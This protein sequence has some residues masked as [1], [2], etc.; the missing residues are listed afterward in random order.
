MIRFHDMRVHT[1]LISLTLVL[2]LLPLLVVSYLY[3]HRFNAALRNAAEV[4]LDHLVRNIHAMCKGQE[5]LVQ[6]K[7]VSDLRV[8]REFLFR[9]GGKIE[10]LQGERTVFDAVHPVTREVVPVDLPL[11]K[12]GDLRLTFDRD[13]VDKIQS[14]MGGICTIL[15]RVEGD[16]LLRIA[17]NVRDREGRRA[18]GTFIPPESPVAQSILSGQ[19]YRGR[20]FVIDAW[21]ITAYDPLRD[22]DGRVIGALNVG[23]R[24]RSSRSLESE[25]Q[26]IRVGET[27]YAYIMD[28]SGVLKVHPA[29]PGENIIDSR[30]SSGFEY[31]RAMIDEAVRLP[32][33]QVGTIRYPWMNPELG[34]KFPRQKITKYLYFRPWDWIIAAGTYEEEIY[35]ALYETERFI[36]IVILVT[37]PMVFLLTI[38]VSK[39]LTGRIQALTQATTRMVDGDL[40]QR[41]EIRGG[42]ELGILGYSFN[43][44]AAQIEDYTQNLQR[45]VEERTRELT[46]SRE[47][48]RNLSRFLNSILESATHYAIIALDFNGEITEFNR[49][50]EKLFGWKKEEVVGRENI[51]ITILAEDR[52]RGIQ[53]EIVRRTRVEGLCELEMDRLSKDGRRFPA[54]TVVTAMMDPSGKVT[55]FV[56]IVRDL[57]LRRSLERQ[58]RETKEFLE[59]IMASSVDGIVTTDLR[60]YITYLNRGME[61]ML[62]YGRE[63]LLGIHI[64][65]LYVRGIQEARDIMAILRTKETTENYGMEVKSKEGR[66][67]SI[68]NSASL[69]RDGEGN[70]IG[71]VGVFKDV[72]EQKR[73][74]AKLRETQAHLVEASKLRALGELVSGVAH[75][76]NNPLMASQTILHVILQNLH[77]ECPN[78]DRLEIVRRCN[79]RIEK[80]VD[81]LREFSRQARPELRPIDINQPVENA[82]LITGQQLL[83]HSIHLNRELTPGLPR[84]RGDGNQIEQV[85]LNLIS[86]ARDALDE[87]E[88]AKELTIR[89][90]TESRDSLPWVVASVR[91]T[92][93]GIPR[94]I[95]EKVMEPFFTT[96]PVGRGTGL[97]LSLCFKIVEDHGG[98]MEMTSE[99]GVGT[100]VKLIFPAE[101]SDKE[102]V[103]GQADFDRG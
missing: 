36:M 20:A 31:I 23:V 9:H 103:N 48:H 24:E 79:D 100:E 17:T 61:E 87:A 44:M 81:H 66:I 62:K 60:G 35:Q 18:G 12:I 90:F 43:R 34:E 97:G 2:V 99:V 95:L 26:A 72:T 39:V 6:A 45:M 38:A 68:M 84:V 58:L 25:V 13:F 27:G 41:V 101:G 63:E 50:A 46:E 82:L 78:K 7:V 16:R 80:I 47:K 4:D 56:E 29:K 85:F 54:H 86:N 3:T 57:T 11:W 71:T 64:S 93:V 53:T 5:E 92:G 22:E 37:V 10:V 75:E 88:G 15:Q 77:E 52:S 70:L 67:L 69:L 91:D 1:K 40:S 28:S 94:E 14:V 33:G 73:L 59:N 76:L 19:P 65:N 83:D 32:E 98:R 89:T 74:E 51:G 8:V 55:G 30:D 102:R 96:K 21:Y 42:D 49:G